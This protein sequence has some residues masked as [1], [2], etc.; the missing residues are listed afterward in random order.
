M[1]SLLAKTSEKLKMAGSVSHQ[2][3]FDHGARSIEH[4][5]KK[6]TK[7]QRRQECEKGPCCPD[8]NRK[9]QNVF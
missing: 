9:N 5:S 4:R 7:K 8:H 6:L 2:I 3:Y 1:A